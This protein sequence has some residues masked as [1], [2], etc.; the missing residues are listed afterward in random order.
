MVTTTIN[1]TQNFA[2]KIPTA[3]K[4]IHE[5]SIYLKKKKKKHDKREVEMEKWLLMENL[6]H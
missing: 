3:S 1:L 2:I 4:I 5:I 6:L